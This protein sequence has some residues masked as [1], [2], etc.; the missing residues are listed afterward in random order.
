MLD[1]T[2]SLLIFEHYK[3][4]NGASH[5]LPNFLS[6]VFSLPLLDFLFLLG[7][8]ILGLRILRHA[9]DSGNNSVKAEVNFMIE[10][11]GNQSDVFM[12]DLAIRELDPHEHCSLLCIEKLVVR[13]CPVNDN[14]KNE[15]N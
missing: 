11:F 6:L 3:I 10:T 4:F 9:L 7:L 1:Q 12:E 15:A 8:R 5:L 14:S 2:N 13:N